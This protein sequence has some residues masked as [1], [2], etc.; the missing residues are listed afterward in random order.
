MTCNV[1]LV[2]EVDLDSVIIQLPSYR[3]CDKL[4]V[5]GRS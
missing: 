1:E 4:G 3:T 2:D 5:G